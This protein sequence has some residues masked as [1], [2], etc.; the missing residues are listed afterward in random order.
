MFVN[1]NFIHENKLYKTFMNESEYNKLKELQIKMSKKISTICPMTFYEVEMLIY[2][3]YEPL[4]D[5]VYEFKKSPTKETFAKIIKVLEC[6][7]NMIFDVLKEDSIS[8]LDA[9]AY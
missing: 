8:N 4:T 3:H 7:Y 2:S 9:I 5:A 1:Q 6:L